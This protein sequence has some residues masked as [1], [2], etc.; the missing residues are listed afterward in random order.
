MNQA[1]RPGPRRTILLHSTGALFALV[2]LASPAGRSLGAETA[3]EYVADGR[4]LKESFRDYLGRSRGAF[5]A[6]G[7]E[8]NEN[9]IFMHP[10]YA[11][12][13]SRFPAQAPLAVFFERRRC[14]ACDVL[15]A[16]P[17]DEKAILDRFQRMEAVQLD[18]ESDTPLITPDGRRLSAKRR[19]EQ[20]GLYYA[21][22]LI[23]FDERG[24]EIMRV[25]SVVWF[26]RLRNVLDYILSG[27]YRQYPTFQLWRQRKTPVT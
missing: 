5:A 1:K 19:A 18:M 25:D 14:H 11:L 21:P 22:T 20:L 24:K 10:P 6:G 9:K 12:D 23:F 3:G 17:L 8:L 15:H 2:L 4:Y 7:E 27:G 13:R 26:Y 16:G